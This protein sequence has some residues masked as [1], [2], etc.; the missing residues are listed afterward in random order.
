MNDI[1]VIIP[2]YNEQ[3][4]IVGTI[5]KVK[6]ELPDVNII[7]V[8]DNSPDKTGQF[9][10]SLFKKNK[11]VKVISRKE[12]SGRGSAVIAGFKKALKNKKAK[13]F[14]EMDADL[15]H[16]PKYIKEL[17][18]KCKKADVVIA[19]RYLPKSKVTGRTLK[20][21]LLS[22]SINIFSRW[23]LKIPITDYTNGFRCYSRKATKALCLHKFISQG[24]IVLSEA[25]FVCK[26]KGFKFD[27][28]PINFHYE[29]VSKSNLNLKEAKEAFVTLLKLKFSN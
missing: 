13:Y 1:E 4:G 23:L 8:D 21:K 20:R 12:K 24:F 5:L 29:F 3:A 17:V 9:V 7:I 25:A 18:E 26:K 22:I 28:V 6:S 16:D 27:E 15:C 10:K 11:K 2:T 19:S 14:I